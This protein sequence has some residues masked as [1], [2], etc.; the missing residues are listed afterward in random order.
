M[1]LNQRKS[2]EDSTSCLQSVSSSISKNESNKINTNTTPTIASAGGGRC[3]ISQYEST[4][5]VEKTIVQA[6]AKGEYGYL[7]TRDAFIM[8]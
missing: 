3:Y 4:V 8:I 5:K 6:E 1:T 7:S 2:G